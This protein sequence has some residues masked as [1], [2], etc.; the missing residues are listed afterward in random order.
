MS[1]A[2]QGVKS[3]G[4]GELLGLANRGLGF[5]NADGIGRE[6]REERRAEAKRVAEEEKAGAGRQ[7]GVF[8]FALAGEEVLTHAPF[9]A[10]TS[11]PWTMRLER[12]PPIPE[13]AK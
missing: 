11:D 9:F 12:A 10:A 1:A 3:Q 2:Y 13:S 7:R 6:K 8:A 5:K 4:L